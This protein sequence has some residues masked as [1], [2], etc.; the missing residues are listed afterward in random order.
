[1]GLLGT[2]GRGGSGSSGGSTNGG[3][4]ST[5]SMD[6]SLVLTFEESSS[7]PHPDESE[8]QL[9]LGLSLGGGGVLKSKSSSLTLNPTP[10]WGQYARILTAQDFHSPAPAA[11]SVRHLDLRSS[12]LYLPL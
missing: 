10:R 4:M 7:Y 6:D 9:G 1:M 5:V 12:P 11:L 3:S 2:V 8:L